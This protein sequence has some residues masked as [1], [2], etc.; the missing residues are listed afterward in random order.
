[1]SLRSLLVLVCCIGTT[2]CN[3]SWDR[4]DELRNQVQVMSARLQ[5]QI[6]INLQQDLLI[7]QLQE[8]T[9]TSLG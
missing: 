6:T 2:L 3:Q 4:F 9:G 1:M 8:R 7:R 5:E